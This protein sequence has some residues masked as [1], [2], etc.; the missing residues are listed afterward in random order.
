MAAAGLLDRP[1]FLAGTRRRS[2][3]G[4][5]RDRW[6]AFSR[7]SAAARAAALQK[8][9]AINPFLWRAGR[10]RVKYIAPWLFLAV[11]AAGWFACGK[12][13]QNQF[14]FDEPTDF[15]CAAAVHFVFK[16][17]VASEACRCFAEDRR[18]GALELLL[19]TPLG[20]E[21]IVRGQRKALWRQFAAPV[22]AVLFVDLFFMNQALRHE[23]M[24]DTES[25]QGDVLLYLITGSFLVMD[26]VAIS[27]LSMRLGLTGRKPIRIIM[28]S[29]WWAVLLPGLVSCGMTAAYIARHFF[30]TKPLVLALIWAIPS[31]T[32]DLIVIA[33]GR[34]NILQRFREGV[35]ERAAKFRPAPPAR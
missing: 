32:A 6:R 2:H 24:T 30:N 13:A 34:C 33:A 31:L 8:L 28:L 19:T 17:W 7:G 1:A 20:A 18:S 14:L 11:A 27:W 9:L 16:I 4:K 3:P 26:L 35:L 10:P 23:N 21:Q 29:F 25:R 12:L 5:W 22:A 15:F